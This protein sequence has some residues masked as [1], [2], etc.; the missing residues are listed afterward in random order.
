MGGAG[1]APVLV[2]NGLVAR[3]FI[4][5]TALPNGVVTTLADAAD[6]P[7]PLSLDYGL[8]NLEHLSTLSLL[9][10]TEDNGRRA[11]S[12][13]GVDTPA[14][15]SVEV[16]DWEK[17]Y[18][19]LDGT[20]QATLEAVVKLGE[21][22]ESHSRIMHF[23]DGKEGG[24]LTLGSWSGKGNC[25]Q[26]VDAFW[27]NQPLGCWEIP[28]TERVVIHLVINTES[29]DPVK[30]Y[31]DG[32]DNLQRIEFNSNGVD[33][34]PPT[35]ELNLGLIEPGAAP[36]F[37]LGN[38]ELGGRSFKGKLYYAAVYNVALDD[39]EVDQ[40]AKILGQSDDP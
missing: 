19:K 38:R 21:V 37:V 22:S 34:G 20:E 6:D 28:F 9:S 35:D 8:S 27:N 17:L 25:G 24:R 12:W 7:L 30:L 18:T 15:A 5:D 4:D 29:D 36:Y 1:G 26:G 32:S 31:L 13:S 2:D 3:Y 33:S 39:D 16:N 40:N 14:R 23:G 10:L 11:L